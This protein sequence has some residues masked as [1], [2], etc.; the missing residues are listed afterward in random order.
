MA[1]GLYIDFT[2]K[3]TEEEDEDEGTTKGGGSDE[4]N[5]DYLDCIDREVHMIYMTIDSFEYRQMK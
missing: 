3:E 5:N 2:V 1:S 4:R